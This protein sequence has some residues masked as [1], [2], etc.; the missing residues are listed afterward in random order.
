MS[1]QTSFGVIS[2]LKTREEDISAMDTYLVELLQS[3]N[4]LRVY[5]ISGDLRPVDCCCFI[6]LDI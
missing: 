3:Q 5:F 1:N 2:P 4:S 6:V